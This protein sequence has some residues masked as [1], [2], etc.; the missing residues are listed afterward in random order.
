MTNFNKL[1][2]LIEDTK[3]RD[4]NVPDGL[5]TPTNAVFADG[6]AYGVFNEDAVNERA[7]GWDNSMTS[8]PKIVNRIKDAVIKNKG[9]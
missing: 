7:R 1:K 3:V 6:M 5:Q 8:S 9:R 2:D 4:T